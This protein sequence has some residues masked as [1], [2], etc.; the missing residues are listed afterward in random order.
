LGYILGEF[1]TNASGE[2]EGCL[3]EQILLKLVFKSIKIY[4]KIFG[5]FSIAGHAEL[6]Y[7]IVQA[8]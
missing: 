6:T 4:E 5:Q 7:D 3:Q 8:S 1:F 2:P